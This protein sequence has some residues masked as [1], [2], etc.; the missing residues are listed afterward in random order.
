MKWTSRREE[1][2]K[3]YYDG[4]FRDVT[5]VSGEFLFPEELLRIYKNR[6]PG[7]EFNFHAYSLKEEHP[8]NTINLYP[9]IGLHDPKVRDNDKA[10]S[11]DRIT[12]LILR[13]NECNKA[14]I[15]EDFSDILGL[16]DKITVVG[17]DEV[18]ELWEPETYEEFDYTKARGI[19]FSPHDK[20]LT[21]F[22]KEAYGKRKG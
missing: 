8:T 5:L 18:V 19:D 9:Y 3:Q 4:E 17:S 22:Q 7:K 21:E 13:L 10:R 20:D 1:R 6:N 14:L 2:E 12:A 11:W 16:R 15:C